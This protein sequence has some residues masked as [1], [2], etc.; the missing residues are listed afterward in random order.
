M[1][2]FMEAYE[3]ETAKQQEQKRLHTKHDIEDENVIVVEK[4]NMVKFSIKSLGV[5]IRSGATIILLCLAAIGLLCIIY[6]ETRQP[7]QDVVVQIFSQLT[8][9]F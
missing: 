3:E 8:Q 6:P 7:L 2:K 9:Y 5:I 1:K 4:S